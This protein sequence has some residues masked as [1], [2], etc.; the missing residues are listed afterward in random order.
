[1]STGDPTN[2]EIATPECEKG[3]GQVKLCPWQILIA[4]GIAHRPAQVGWAA[5]YERTR[6]N[7]LARFS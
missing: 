6:F 5:D 7:S 4:P 2:F 3:L 1:M